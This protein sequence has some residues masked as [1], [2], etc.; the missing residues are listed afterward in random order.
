MPTARSRSPS[1]SPTQDD[2][3]K[4][5]RTH[6]HKTDHPSRYD[7]PRHHSD[8]HKLRS[9][10][11]HIHRE[12]DRDRDLDRRRDRRDRSASTERHL[13]KGKE[14][15][16]DKDQDRYRHDRRR[17]EDVGYRERRRSRSRSRERE[18]WNRRRSKSPTVPDPLDARSDRDRRRD[19][20]PRREHNEKPPASLD[21]PK[22]PKPVLNTPSSHSGVPSKPPASTASV[23]ARD[24]SS[25]QVSSTSLTSLTQPV[26]IT[27][28]PDKPVKNDQI[29]SSAP[30]SAVAKARAIAEARE[31]RLPGETLEQQKLRM[32]RERLEQWK[33]KKALEENSSSTSTPTVPPPISKSE[34][35]QTLPLATKADKGKMEPPSFPIAPKGLPKKPLAADE[36]TAAAL[37]AAAISARLGTVPPPILAPTKLMKNAPPIGIKGLPSKPTFNAFPDPSLNNSKLSSALG[38]EDDSGKT[39]IQKLKFEAINADDDLLK[40][41]EA[42]EDSDEEDLV[43]GGHVGYNKRKIIDGVEEE[44]GVTAAGPDDVNE[45]EGES[46]NKIRLSQAVEKTTKKRFEAVSNVETSV[47]PTQAMDIDQ[48]EID[49]LD[50]YMSGVTDEV[51][52]VNDRDKKKMNQLAAGS[53]KVLEEDEDRIEEDDQAGGSEDEVDKT[54]L[55]PEDIMALAAKK[56]KKKDLAPVDHQKIE[57]ES[58][59]KA[60]YHPPAE[61][62]E[63]TDEQAENIRIAMDGIKI[64]GQ[65]CPKPVMKWSW[66]GLHAACLE[67]IKTLGYKSPTPIQG[68]AVPAIMSGRDVIGVAKTGSGKTLAFLLPMFRHIKDQRPLD[69]LEGPI[70]MIMT[71]TRELATQIYKE[72]RPFLKSLGLRAACAYGGSPLKDNI[73]DMKRGAEVIVCTPGRMIE[74]LTTNSGRVINMRRVT[75]L[76]LDEADRMFDMGFEPQVMKIVNQ[77]QPDRQTV[78]FSATFPKQ[79]EALARKI[80]RRPLEITVGGRSVVA[81][82]IEQIVEVREESTKFNRLLEILGRSYNED[83][84]SRSLVFVDRQESADNLFRDLLKKGYPCLSLHGGKEQVDRDQVIA[85]FKSG[86]TPIVIATSVAARGLDVKQLKLVINY[87]APNHME[88]YVHRAGRTGRAGNKGTCIT[89]IAPDQER[90]AVDLLRALVTSGAKYPEELKTMSDSF[91]EK[92]KSGKAQA[93]GSGFG[94]KGLDRLEKDRDAKS[95]AER[96]AYGEPGGDE[97]SKEEL[98]TGAAG[99]ANGGAASTA[100]PTVEIPEI[101]VEVKRGPA[102]DSNRRSQQAAKPAPPAPVD[103]AATPALTAALKAAQ[104]AAQAKGLDA[105]GIARAQNV[106]ADLNAKLRSMIAAKNA[107]AQAGNHDS[108]NNSNNNM[109]NNRSKDPDATDFHA[110]VPINDY[111]QKARWKVTNKETMV[112]L[113]DSTGASVTNKGVFYEKGKEPGPDEPPKLHLLVESNE[114]WRVQRAITEIKHILIEATTQALEAESRNPGHHQASGS[115]NRTTIESENSNA[116]SFFK[117]DDENLTDK[118]S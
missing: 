14:R 97:A 94:G 118:W 29:E 77:I 23:G 16:R 12:R 27:A 40:L 24:S 71:P 1:R 32:K 59:R 106:V 22:S 5:R 36:A 67:V 42:E 88:D 63:M 69:A 55:R 68:Q 45:E 48:E 52:K 105:S 101:N 74:L 4:R 53:K 51:I 65:D 111:P 116:A 99:T 83:S 26:P 25:Q 2:Y 28:T 6:S 86:V 19:H 115:T 43:D 7:S 38:T 31:G 72:G 64:R 39:K 109:N 100:V 87:D 102:P 76:V 49:P 47:Q 91:L 10:D 56:L 54:N 11:H 73:A 13:T 95:R 110:I 107:Q 8:S 85:D 98:G 89:F 114:E 96:S 104:A 60:F 108:N 46:E 58:F 78:L 9:S 112:Q 34:S 44:P 20:P 82:E 79:M 80:L 81:S 57:Y 30:G 50:A 113:V 66:F 84:E 92:I 103:V 62:E 35:V 21:R 93:S 61:V 33:A 117:P 18:R 15:D 37:A 70:A 90:Y 3:S 75:Y 17:H 41:V